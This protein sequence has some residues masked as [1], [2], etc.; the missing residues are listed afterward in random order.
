[1]EFK[2][3]KYINKDFEEQ[4]AIA[5]ICEDDTPNIIMTGDYYHDKTEAKIEGFLIGVRFSD[6]D[7]YTIETEYI[8]EGHE[9]YNEL[10]FCAN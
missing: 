5:E 3:K 4:M 7:S 8:S 1:M 2:F 6:E 9:L 10:Q